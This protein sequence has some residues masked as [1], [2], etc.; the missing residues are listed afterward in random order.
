M[1]PPFG[2]ATWLDYAVATLDLPFSWGEGQK[3]EGEQAAMGELVE[4]RAQRDALLAACKGVLAWKDWPE[5]RGAFELQGLHGG[6]SDEVCG[7]AQAVWC[8]VMDAIK[9]CEQ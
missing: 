7:R 3:E 2:Y 4:L 1:N 5:V 6:V 9:K 8:A